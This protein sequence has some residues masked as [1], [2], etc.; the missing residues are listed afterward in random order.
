MVAL[1]EK[2]TIKGFILI[3]MISQAALGLPSLKLN[4][5]LGGDI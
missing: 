4:I 5:A 3:Y 1:L 2:F